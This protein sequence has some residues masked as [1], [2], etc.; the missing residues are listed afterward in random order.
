[1]TALFG[2]VG[3]FVEGQ[4]WPQ[5]VERLRHFF[6]ANGVEDADKKRAVFL[7]II[8]PRTYKLLSSLTA[9]AAP[10]EKSFDELVKH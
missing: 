5:Y 10:G 9:T 4:E 7:S 3:E 6:T 1:M 8:K 2:H